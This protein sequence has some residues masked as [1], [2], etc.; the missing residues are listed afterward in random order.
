MFENIREDLRRGL[1]VNHLGDF[2]AAGSTHFP[3]KARLSQFFRLGTQCVIIHRFGHWAWKLRIPIVR[4]L[5]LAAFFLVQLPLRALAGVNIPYTAKIGP[6]LV[7]H[8]W[9]GVFLPPCRMGRNLHFNHGVVVGWSCREVGDDVYFG[10]GCKV[11][12]PVKIGN[13]VKIGANAVV[14][15]DIPDDCTAV[16]I[17]AR[18][19][20]RK[21]PF[22]GEKVAPGPDRRQGL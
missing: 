17:P 13:R 1:M 21:K 11:I 19:L 7:I 2:L 12:G 10:T 8:T 20:P 5:L 22:G 16:G 14:L 3:L 15:E 9:S 6:G 4:H 18:I